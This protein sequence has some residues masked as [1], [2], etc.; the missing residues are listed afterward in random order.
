MEGHLKAQLISSLWNYYLF[1]QTAEDVDWSQ[2]LV[3]VF[4]GLGDSKLWEA[5]QTCSCLD[6]VLQEMSSYM[7]QY[8]GVHIS[9][10]FC[11]TWC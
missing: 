2:P 8:A 3:T 10:Y 11:T 6:A 5:A 4:K 9:Q 1:L 7:I